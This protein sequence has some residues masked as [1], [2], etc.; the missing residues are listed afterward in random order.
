M[1][2]YSPIEVIVPKPWRTIGRV[3]NILFILTTIAYIWLLF[4]SS[5]QADEELI[6]VGYFSFFIAPFWFLFLMPLY[7]NRYPSWFV[8]LVGRKNLIRLIAD[9][10]RNVGKDRD[11][12][13]KLSEPKKWFDDQRIF[14]VV[15]FIGACV[16]GL[17]QGAGLL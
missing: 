2:N 10:K 7:L 13:A 14:W 15:I 6:G 12:K 5:D 4:I 17:L 3:C 9:C 11:I 1:K 8:R 16:L